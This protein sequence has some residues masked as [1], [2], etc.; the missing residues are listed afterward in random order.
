[1][2]FALE[3]PA[4]RNGGAIPRKYSRGGGNVSPPFSLGRALH[5]NEELCGDRRRSRCPVRDVPSLG[6][7]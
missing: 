5:G 7:L 2:T 3:S 4:F 6:G 1:M